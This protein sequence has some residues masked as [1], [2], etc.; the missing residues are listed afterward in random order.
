MKRKN[1]SFYDTLLYLH[2]NDFKIKNIFIDASNLYFDL[3]IETDDEEIVVCTYLMDFIF[4][5]KLNNDIA[6]LVINSLSEDEIKSNS[7][8]EEYLLEKISKL[9]VFI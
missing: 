1:M 8:I 6:I 9:K 5:N 7:K 2:S 3:I 4:N